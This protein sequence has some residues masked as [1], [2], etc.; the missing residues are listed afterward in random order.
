MD[1]A[2]GR[3][4]FHAARGRVEAALALPPNERRERRR[5]CCHPALSMRF[6]A[7]TEGDRRTIVLVDAAE[8]S[9][10]AVASGAIAVLPVDASAALIRLA[11][12]AADAGF[13]LLPADLRGVPH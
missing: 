9:E 4:A 11:D 7:R 1:S 2:G 5:R 3:V 8:A 10:A 13:A 12:E 6:R